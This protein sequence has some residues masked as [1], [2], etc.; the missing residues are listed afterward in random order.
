MY[1]TAMVCIDI[2]TKYVAVVPTKGKTESDLA[3][4]MIECLAKMGKPPQILYTD[5][6][7]CIRNSGLF[8]KYVDEH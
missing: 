7:T 3:H 6:E 8:Q 1:D 5:G 4:G 2:F